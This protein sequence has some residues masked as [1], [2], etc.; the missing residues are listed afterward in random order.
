MTFSRKTKN[1]KRYIR[2]STVGICYPPRTRG[3]IPYPGG[4]KEI[5]TDPNAATDKGRIVRDLGI[6]VHFDDDPRHVE[7]I[8][9]IGILLPSDISAS[10]E[11]GNIL[12]TAPDWE[13][14][15]HF[16]QHRS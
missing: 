6:L 4:K 14:V 15:G 1:E 11:A 8:P 2:P 13:T 10:S 12:P 16:S 5:D 3:V 9:G 7:S